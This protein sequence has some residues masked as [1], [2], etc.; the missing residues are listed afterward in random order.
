MITFEHFKDFTTTITHAKLD[1]IKIISRKIFPKKSMAEHDE[2]LL[3]YLEST[4]NW[5]FGQRKHL[6][7]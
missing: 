6:E 1:H 4:S 5:K 3:F 2:T 7:S